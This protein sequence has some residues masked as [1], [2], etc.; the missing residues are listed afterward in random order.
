MIV[1]TIGFENVENVF[2]DGLDSFSIINTW[3]T[4]PI[5]NAKIAQHL[6]SGAKT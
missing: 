1:S 5:K 6:F 4:H 3:N 2:A